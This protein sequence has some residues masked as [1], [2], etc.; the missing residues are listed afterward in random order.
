MPLAHYAAMSLRLV[1]IKA[2]M[3]VAALLLAATASAAV[4]SHFGE[5]ME[6]ALTCRS[7]WSTAWWRGYFRSY[8]GTPLRTWG[9]A[10][11]FD[12]QGA[13]LGGVTAKEAFVNLPTSGA[14]MVGVLIAQP[15]D[16]VKQ[17]IETT[18][19]THFEPIAGPYPRFLSFSGSVLV[20]LSNNQTKW[21]CARWNLGNRP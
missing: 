8:L 13:Q 9:E 19:S 1:H 6:A 3:L 11:W 21:Y 7:E 20:G 5:Q 15:V 2:G 14:L 18:L 12:S 10:E 16:K 17:T 4:P